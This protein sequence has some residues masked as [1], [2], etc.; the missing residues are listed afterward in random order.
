MRL[1]TQGPSSSGSPA[2]P[3]GI[4]STIASMTSGFFSFHS[5]LVSVMNSPGQMAFTVILRL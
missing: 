3:T 5:R 2:R 1:R 4:P